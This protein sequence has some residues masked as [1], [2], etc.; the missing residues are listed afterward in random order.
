MLTILKDV[1]YFGTQYEDDTKLYEVQRKVAPFEAASGIMTA[2]DVVARVI[3]S[4]DE[5]GFEI[6]DAILGVFIIDIKAIEIQ[7][8][9]QLLSGMVIRRI[10]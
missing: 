10:Q 8:I 2:D 1:L 4:E 9:N 5:F 6:V 3:E 7:K